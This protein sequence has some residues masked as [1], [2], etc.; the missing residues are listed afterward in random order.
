MAFDLDDVK[1]TSTDVMVAAMPADSTS[2]AKSLLHSKSNEDQPRIS[3]SGE[4]LAY[5]SDESGRGEV[6][7]TRFP[8]GEGKW[9]VSVDGGDRPRWDPAGGRI[10]FASDKSL[11]AV[12]VAETPE[13][14]LGNPRA[15]FDTGSAGVVL[16]RL[17]SFDADRGGKRFVMSYRGVG[18]TQKTV[19]RFVVVENWPAEFAKGDK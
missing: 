12:D 16:G 14:R 15:L 18:N 10:Y 19:F 5:V 1:T 3:P 17:S 13:L 2:D 7:L 6:Y 9:Q 8:T 4:Y 11:M